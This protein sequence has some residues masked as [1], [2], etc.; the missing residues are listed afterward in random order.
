MKS[1]D[2]HSQ[3]YSSITHD[4]CSVLL[5]TH[6]T[7][8]KSHELLISRKQ[9]FRNFFS[10]NSK[11]EEEDHPN[12]SNSSQKRNSEIESNKM[13]TQKKAINWKHGSNS[14]QKKKQKKE[15]PRNSTMKK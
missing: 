15:E 3:T 4:L 5:G 10:D 2:F 14:L 11:I 7:N 9:K 8:Y 6:T 1:L 13:E 12:G